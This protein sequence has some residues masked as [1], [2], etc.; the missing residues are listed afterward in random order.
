VAAVVIPILPS[1]DFDVTLQFW[2]EFGFRENSRWVD[3]YLVL[4]HDALGVELHFWFDPGVDRWM[5]DVGCYVRFDTPDEALAC[6]RGWEHIEVAHP[7]VFGAPGTLPHGAT[8]F[9][10]IDLHGNLVRFGGFP[11]G[12]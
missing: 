9:Q 11:P 1:A 2:R 8:E 10:V 6:H 3:E 7:A 12:D 4:R 5:N